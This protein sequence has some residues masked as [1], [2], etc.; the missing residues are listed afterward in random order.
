M[1]PA[2]V[3][4]GSTLGLAL[5]L[6]GAGLAMSLGGWGSSIG[7][8]MAGMA[9]AGVITED[10]N[11]F[12]KMI[13]FVAIPGT[14]GIYSFVIFFIIS[15]VKLNMLGT[16]NLPTLHQGLQLLFIGFC[17]GLVEWGSA[18]H[19]GKVA[20]A[21][22]GIVAKRP[23][24]AGKGLILPAFVETYAVIALVGTLLLILPMKIG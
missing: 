21:A 7:V 12:G 10:P 22:I 13:P 3:Q 23:E 24:Q 1:D 18:V 4:S 11:K 9:A 2:V 5:G 8:G 17:A 6:L 16:P 19:Q 14:Q 20:A 15:I